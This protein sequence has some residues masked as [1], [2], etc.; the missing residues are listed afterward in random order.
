MRSGRGRLGESEAFPVQFCAQH[1][2]CKLF[3]LAGKSS[4]G[5]AS[6]ATTTTGLAGCGDRLLL[7]GTRFIDDGRADEVAPFGPRTVVVTNVTV[8][9]EILQDEPGVRTALTDA[10]VSDDLVLA[11]NAL[12]V[13]E[14]L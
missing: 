12:R 6:C 5:A 10:A 2:S 1:F 13:V 7:T 9:Q 3:C 11:G 14:L 8:A 4:L